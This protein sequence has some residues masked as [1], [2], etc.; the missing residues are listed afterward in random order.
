MKK[1]SSKVPFGLR[2]VELA[3]R[4][5][6]ELEDDSKG[7]RRKKKKRR[8]RREKVDIVEGEGR[9]EASEYC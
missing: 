1:P 2:I 9:R 3:R 7:E 8:K 4:R 5:T 6:A